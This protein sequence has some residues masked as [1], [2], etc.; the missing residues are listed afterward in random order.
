MVT[1]CQQKEPTRNPS[2]YVVAAHE[3]LDNPSTPA[4]RLELL[5]FLTL[6][7]AILRSTYAV[8]AIIAIIAIVAIIAI[9]ANYPSARVIPFPPRSVDLCVS[10]PPLLSSKA[11]LPRQPISKHV[12][13]LILLILL[14]YRPQRS[15]YWSCTQLPG[16]GPARL[17]VGLG[18]LGSWDSGISLL[19]HSLQALRA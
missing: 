11:N 12:Q 6:Q 5:C 18:S 9:H 19:N 4:P 14:S 3:Q 17:G 13:P 8:I 16:H 15:S 10:P 1:D 7:N 2:M